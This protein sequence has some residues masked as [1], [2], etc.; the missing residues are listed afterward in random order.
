[1]SDQ[2]S[3]EVAIADPNDAIF[4]SL[5]KRDLAET[6]LGS[7]LALDDRLYEALLVQTVL[8]HAQNG[9]KIFHKGGMQYPFA[10]ISNI[11]EAADLDL[12]KIKNLRQGLIDDVLEWVELAKRDQTNR[13]VVGERP[14]LGVEF[15]R[16]YQIDSEFVLKGMVLAGTMDNYTW[17]QAT[18][19][20]YGG[21][22]ME[23]QP[24]VIGGGETYLVDVDVLNNGEFTLLEDF[25]NEENSQEI[26]DELRKRGIITTE[27]NPK[28]EVAYFR[29]KRGLGT[30]DDTAFIMMGE[31]YK[32]KGEIRSLSAFLGGFIVD[33]VDTYDKC[34]V[35][36]V[37]GGYDERI[38]KEIMVALPSLV[39]DDEITTLIYYSAKGNGYPLPSCSHK[40]LIQIISA[41]PKIPMLLHH[42]K[43][44][45][46]GRHAP[47]SVGF[48]R[49]PSPRFYKGV[50]E[51][52]DHYHQHR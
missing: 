37:E 9:H 21:K 44:L 36:P 49:M 35:R 15:L 17:R 20:K 8:G 43:F 51:R 33:G 27:S 42:Y 52:I 40:R 41:D 39:S 46:T 4:K 22:T 14:L 12:A 1:M 38:G 31:M 23:G 24:L 11:I 26:I 45:E 47:F 25:A 18:V 2:I 30:S 5:V 7:P 19:K 32:E 29:R 3:K 13:L 16:G 28:A 48:E 10:T 50:K 6:R 34:S